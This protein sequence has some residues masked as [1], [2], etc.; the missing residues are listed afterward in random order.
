M[1][2]IPI[3]KNND[4]CFQFTP[5]NLLDNLERIGPWSAYALAEVAIEHFHP[6]VKKYKND[7]LKLIERQVHF[8]NK[9]GNFTWHDWIVK[10]Q[11]EVGYNSPNGFDKDFVNE[12]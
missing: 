8:C 10:Y 4:D 5:D 2:I 12:Y 6:S 1:E 7:P 3:I 9:A 11:K